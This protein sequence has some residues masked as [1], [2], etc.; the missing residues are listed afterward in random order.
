MMY[1]KSTLTNQCYEM[2]ELP[3]FM[4]GYEVISKETYNEYLEQ[5]PWLKGQK[6]LAGSFYPIQSSRSSPPI[7][8]Y[9]LRRKWYLC[10]LAF[11]VNHN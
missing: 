11:S 6:E 7:I 3:K 9:L 4:N 8:L 5:H 10:I 2:D 1:L